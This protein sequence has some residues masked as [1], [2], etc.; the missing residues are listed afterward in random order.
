MTSESEEPEPCDEEEEACNYHAEQVLFSDRVFRGLSLKDKHQAWVDVPFQV[1]TAV[2]RD[3]YLGNSYLRASFVLVPSSPSLLD[4]LKS[5]STWIPPVGGPSSMRPEG[6]TKGARERP[7]VDEALDS[8]GLSLPLLEFLEIPS[9]CPQE[10][11]E[12]FVLEHPFVITRIQLRVADETRLFNKEMYDKAYEKLKEAKDEGLA[13]QRTYRT[14]GH[15]ETLLE[16]YVPSDSGVNMSEFVYPPYLAHLD[17]PHR[18]MDLVRVPVTREDC[19]GVVPPPDKDLMNITLHLSYSGRTP[20]K[21]VIG[22]YINFFAFPQNMSKSDL[23][24]DYQENIPIEMLHGLF[25]HR[26]S[27]EARPRRRTFFDVASSVLAA[28][29][30]LLQIIYWYRLNSTA[31]IS[32][33]GTLLCGIAGLVAAIMDLLQFWRQDDPSRMLLS[34]MRGF[35]ALLMLKRISRQFWTTKTT[36]IEHRIDSTSNVGIR[37]MLIYLFILYQLSYDYILRPKIIPEPLSWPDWF[38]E[39]VLNAIQVA[40]MNLQI[41][42]TYHSRVFAGD[43]KSTALVDMMTEMIRIASLL[44]KLLGS[45]AYSEFGINMTAWLVLSMQVVKTWQ[46]VT[47]PS[48]KEELEDEEEQSNDEDK[49]E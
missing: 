36:H 15:W 21:L 20:A 34:I 16:L 32:V 9:M 27:E 23:V 39:R 11:Y 49:I 46:A 47:L 41:R 2:F 48:S 24:H 43:Y 5:Y 17:G 45:R 29:S 38:R 33:H 40:G 19:Y 3:G 37:H 8:F 14:H 18:P 42:F 31:W 44:P 35:L 4:N 12:S 25:G 1:P 30:W 28:T 7:L 10:Y 22:E 26:Y 6:M 13:Y